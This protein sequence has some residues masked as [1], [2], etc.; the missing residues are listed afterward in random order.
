M[1]YERKEQIDLD[2]VVRDGFS[3]EVAFKLRPEESEKASQGR[4]RGCLS[5]RNSMCE[6]FA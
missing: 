4:G 5:Q 6:G 2:R 1:F 3:E